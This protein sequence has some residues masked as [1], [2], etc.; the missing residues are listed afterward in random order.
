MSGLAKT[1]P[2][3][4]CV[5][6]TTPG[7]CATTA[8]RCPSSRPHTCAALACCWTMTPATCPSTTPWAPT[9]STPMTSPSSSRCVLSSTC[10]TSV[11]LS[12][13]DFPFQTTLRLQILRTKKD[14]N[15]SSTQLTECS[16]TK[17]L[18]ASLSHGKKTN[19]PSAVQSRGWK[20]TKP[21][22]QSFLKPYSYGSLVS[23]EEIIYLN[24]KHWTTQLNI[25]K[26]ICFTFCF[27]HPLCLCLVSLSPTGRP[28]YI[29]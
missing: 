24:E 12:S 23:L 25:V 27:A 15:V 26:V 9:I 16:C 13:Q 29:Q 17:W 22:F 5:A 6:A 11:W 2:R 19:V 7:W 4:C 8:K 14:P 1:L 10:G 21:W 28:F 3:G 20:Y 18:C